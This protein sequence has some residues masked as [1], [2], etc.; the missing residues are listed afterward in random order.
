[1]SVEYSG[2]RAHM[3]VGFGGS[4]FNNGN[5]SVSWENPF[6]PIGNTQLLRAALEPDS[7]FQ[8]FNFSGA[9][10]VTPG[11][12]LLGN[13]TIGHIK[14]D[15]TFLPYSINPDFDDLLLP[16]ASLN[17][18]ID[19]GIFNLATRLM[20]RLSPNLKLSARIKIDER[21]NSS[22]VNFYT[23]VSYDYVLNQDTANRPYSFKRN[24]YSLELDYRSHPFMRW[25]AGVKRNEHARTL[26]SVTDT[27]ERTWW[28]ELNFNHWATAQ[29]RLRLEASDRD[30]SPYVQV[31]NPGLR[32]NVLMRK[33]NLAGRDRDR[34]V[35]ELD[36]SPADRLSAGISY[37]M[38]KDDYQQSVL[39]VL[40]SEE[41]SFSIDLG[42][43]LNNK[44][45]LHMFFTQDSF[46]SE[47]AG[48]GFPGATAWMARTEDRFT[49]F[50]AGFTGKLS[51]KMDISLDYISSDSRGRIGTDSGSGEAPFPELES[52]LV[53]TRVRLNY[54]VNDQ[55]SWILIGEHENYRSK[56]WQIDGLGNDGIS[57]ILSFG[58]ESPDYSIN[59]LRLMASY[60][61]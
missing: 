59:L 1:M 10:R 11:V 21:D 48:A 49:T 57:A 20:A 16:R 6:N 7:N 30:N 9:Y 12:R 46:D 35:I 19:T 23:P 39:G 8:Q 3:R 36:L 29:L 43:A 41:R 38:S 4:W 18:K 24:R 55:W 53:N 28:G 25:R 32:E 44:L 5:A 52:D 58:G 61:F 42:Y 2:E 51:D 15:Q 34:F 26:Q 37:Y 47:I 27:K 33:F 56:D 60:R 40:H 14:Q 50:G 31:I 54:T 13:V 17:G 45:G 22:P